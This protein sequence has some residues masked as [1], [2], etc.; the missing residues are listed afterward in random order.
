MIFQART[1]GGTAPLLIGKGF[2]IDNLSY[3]SS[4]VEQCDNRHADGDGD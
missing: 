3:S 4:T 1:S 2:L